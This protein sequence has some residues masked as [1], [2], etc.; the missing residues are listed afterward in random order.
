M[1]GRQAIEQ[2]RTSARNPQLP[3]RLHN[4]KNSPEKEPYLFT[5]LLV[6]MG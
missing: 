5:A 4:R 2:S 1:G 6:E 3:R